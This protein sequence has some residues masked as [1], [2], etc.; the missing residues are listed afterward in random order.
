MREPLVLFENFGFKYRAQVEPTLYDINL[1]IYP[2]EKIL[3][4]GPSGSGKSTLAHCINGLIPFNYPGA[5][6]GKLTVNGTE[7]KDQSVFSL[8]HTVGT[9]LQDTDGQFVG[10]TAGEDIA[11]SLENNCVSQKEM[12]TRVKRAAQLTGI[13]DALDVSPFEL[14]GGQKQRVSMSGVIVDDVRVLL[15]D[16]PLANL[17]PATGKTAIALIDR[18]MRETETT[19]IIIE[20]RLEDVL[21]RP[22]DRVILMA[23]GRIVADES[24]GA[25][26]C[27]DWLSRYGIREPLYITAL[28]YAGVPVSLDKKPEHMET[29]ALAGN[30]KKA[31]ARWY[32]TEAQPH[33]LPTGTE[34][35]R[36]RHLTFR[37]P[38]R[39]GNALNNINFSVSKGEMTAIV[40]TNGAGKSTLAKIICG[41]EKP[42]GGSIS[43]GGAEI[44]GDSI[45][46]RAE[47]IGYVMQ[48]PN[49]MI[50]KP[51]IFDEIA[52][53]LRNKKIPEA[54]IEARVTEML[55]VCGLKPFRDWPVSA[56]SYGQKKRVTIASVLVMEPEMIIL[57]EPTAGQDFRHYTE[58]MAFLQSLNDR[59]VTVLMITHDMHLMLEY[60]PRA[61]VLSGGELIADLSSAELLCDRNLIE[62]ASLKETSLFRLA[63]LCGINDA[64]G[65]VNR[66][67]ETEKQKRVESNV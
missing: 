62:A 39:K 67:V 48:N 9:V 2:G 33:A 32:E 60:A 5:C 18:V 24:P 28:K 25:L 64:I 66:F 14:S 30:D 44:S 37:Y 13:G 51:L 8:S 21:Y 38:G 54:E 6:T 17:D 56:L 15:F 34:L 45:P 4:A 61:I 26:L 7:T 49:Q 23:E 31:V 65:F 19:V 58:F 52:L 47:R 43:L 59:G 27:G 46:K 36:I 22:V 42:D 53:G 55:S 63:E 50:C 3:I 16:E 35:L 41:F 20:H 11:F 57:D 10:L 29:L 1:A 40:G 12:V